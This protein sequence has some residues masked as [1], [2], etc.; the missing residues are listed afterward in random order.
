MNKQLLVKQL[1]SL[2]KSKKIV[3]SLEC[4]ALQRTRSGMQALMNS[5]K[6]L[7]IQRDMFACVP[8]IV[9][10]CSIA[11]LRDII[12]IGNQAGLC[13]SV[14]DG[15]WKRL[16]KELRLRGAGVRLWV[17]GQNFFSKK[18]HRLL[19][20]GLVE[21]HY[22]PKQGLQDF[23]TPWVATW[24][25]GTVSNLYVIY[26]KFH[27][28]YQHEVITKE[29]LVTQPRASAEIVVLPD[30]PLSQT[31]A[32]EMY[33]MAVLH[34][35]Y[36]EA[37]LSECAVKSMSMK[38]AKDNADELTQEYNIKLSTVTQGLITQELNELMIGN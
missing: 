31:Q 32:L 12:L 6:Y 17:S 33:V 7:S 16:L 14:S 23:V 18:Y 34:N 27:N 35:A 13:F 11:S 22:I 38:L 5:R 29:V 26:P 25:A 28:L 9:R 21:L 24:Q 1:Q 4:I 8:Q 20:L 3:G 2:K 37:Y 10:S 15:L 19:A 30:L 36:H